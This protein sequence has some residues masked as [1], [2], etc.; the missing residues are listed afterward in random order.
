MSTSTS[1]SAPGIPTLTLNPLAPL[2]TRILSLSGFPP[3]L[4]TRDI[5]AVFSPWEDDSGGFKIKWLDDTNALVIFNDAAVAKRA[6]LSTLLSPPPSL[7]TSAGV[8]A[9]VRPYSGEDAQ[10][11]I[12][13]VQNRSRSRSTAQGGPG[14]QPAYGA[15]GGNEDGQTQLGLGGSS[16]SP[17]K[18]HSP[19]FP[20]PTAV[21]LPAANS[22]RPTSTTT[23]NS[24][25]HAARGHRRHPSSTSTLPAKPVAAALFDAAQGGPSP[26][27]H[28][29]NAAA[30]EK[31]R[32]RA[33]AN[34]TVN[35]EEEEQQ[36]EGREKGDVGSGEVKASA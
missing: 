27:R 13:S 33:V 23:N 32:E 22:S 25:N 16:S 3:E 19:A 28:L 9:K 14:A 34:E 4:K 26:A 12:A 36:K 6:Y 1:T 35:E 5:Q 31:E 8:A 10:D 11:I 2:S 29:A 20:A 17:K 24:T 30:A 18:S 21:P 15:S 7:M